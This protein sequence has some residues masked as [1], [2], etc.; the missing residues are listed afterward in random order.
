MAIMNQTQ[1][2]RYEVNEQHNAYDGQIVS[3]VY[4][5]VSPMTD[6]K[7]VILSSEKKGNM[8]I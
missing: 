3:Y 5:Y 8:I 1:I 2:N 4:E 7:I 6:V